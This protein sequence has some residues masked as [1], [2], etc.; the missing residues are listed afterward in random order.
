VHRNNQDFRANPG[1]VKNFLVRRNNGF[2]DP[3]SASSKSLIQNV[4][5]HRNKQGGG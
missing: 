4:K 3:A 1:E 2:Q 5:M